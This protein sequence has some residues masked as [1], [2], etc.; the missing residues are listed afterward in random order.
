[1]ILEEAR[2]NAALMKLYADFETENQ[3][4]IFNYAYTMTTENLAGYYK[5]ID[6]FSKV[7]CVTSSGDHMLNCVLHGAKDVTMFDS[8][9]L[10]YFVVELKLAVLVQEPRETFMRFFMEQK[11]WDVVHP[12]ALFFDHH[13]YER[14]KTHLKPTVQ[15]FWDAFYALVK[16]HKVT[17]V[18]SEIFK[19][20]RYEP[21]Q[22]L[23]ANEY[24]WDDTAYALVKRRLTDVKLTYVDANLKDLFR[25]LPSDV[26]FNT[27]LFSNISD[28]AAQMFGVEDGAVSM[29]TYNEFLEKEAKAHL[30]FNGQ[31][32]FAYIYQ[33]MTGP[34]WTEIDRIEKLPTYFGDYTLRTFPAMDQ[35]Q[36]NDRSLV[37]CVLIKRR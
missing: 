19:H 26:R 17:P 13:I 16:E 21:Q 4:G 22:L 37:D 11:P 31:M 36:L 33:A 15:Q 29:Q 12:E 1:M 10:A 35:K 34:G 14:V 24:L 3:P 8:N 18:Q 32:C 9:S 28:Y 23:E 20:I 25:V 5:Y 7:L 6:N 30:A 27:M 2:L